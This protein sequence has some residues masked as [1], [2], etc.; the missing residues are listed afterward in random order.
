MANRILELNLVIDF[1]SGLKIDVFTNVCLPENLRARVFKS[2]SG[3]FA[4][5]YVDDL[6]CDRVIF[7]IRDYFPSTRVTCCKR[8]L[9]PDSK[10]DVFLTSAN[11]LTALIRDLL[12]QS[13]GILCNEIEL[14]RS[15]DDLDLPFE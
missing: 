3:K 2:D 7:A 15:S 8:T 9:S 5:T 14:M 6:I 4:T 10:F 13:I 12:T 1:Q 11:S